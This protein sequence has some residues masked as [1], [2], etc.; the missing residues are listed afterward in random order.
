[1]KAYI[2]PR[3]NPY[4]AVTNDKGQFEIKDVPAGENVEFQVWQ[5]VAGGPQIALVIPG[6]TDA[7]GRIVKNL[8]DGETLDLGEIKVPASAFKL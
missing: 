6:V 2:L 5:E 1:M 3:D 7:K 4:F 8:T